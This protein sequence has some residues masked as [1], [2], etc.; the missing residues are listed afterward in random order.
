MAEIL[1][2]ENASGAVR[3]T[4]VAGWSGLIPTEALWVTSDTAW[5]ALKS[6]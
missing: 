1:S 5:I 3:I 2:F 4:T 6:I